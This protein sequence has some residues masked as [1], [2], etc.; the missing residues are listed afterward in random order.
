MRKRTLKSGRKKKERQ[1]KADPKRRQFCLISLWRNFDA[2]CTVYHGERA[3]FHYYQCLQVI[4]RMQIAALTRLWGLPPEFEVRYASLQRLVC[5]NFPQKTSRDIWTLHLSLLP[6]SPTAEPLFNMDGGLSPSSSKTAPGEQSDG[7][8]TDHGRTDD[9]LGDSSSSSSGSEDTDHD[10]ELDELM[11]E[12][13][14]TPSSSDQEDEG[15]ATLRRAS[16]ATARKRPTFNKHDTPTNTIVVLVV[17][18]W[19]LRLP[20]MYID[21][22][23]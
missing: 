13:S 12:N 3:R 17:A 21:F 19:T 16:V 11:R 23:R 2:V 22:V 10:S 8:E 15:R 6:K 7:H 14:L 20:V 18:C 1:S 4:L 9:T 5:A